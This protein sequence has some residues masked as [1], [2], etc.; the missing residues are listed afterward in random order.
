MARDKNK[1]LKSYKILGK[2][3]KEMRIKNKLSQENLAFMLDSARNY[4]GCIERAEKFPSFA[5][6]LDIAEAL[7][8][9]LSD[10]TKNI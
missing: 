1:H 10:L 8:C 4:I 6:V 9:R 2:N 5:F 3:I 7:N